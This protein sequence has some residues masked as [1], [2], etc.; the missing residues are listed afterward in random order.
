MAGHQE[1]A[2]A[3]EGNTQRLAA[4]EDRA[5][6][7]TVSEGPELDQAVLSTCCY[8]GR[9]RWMLHN[10]AHTL[11]V[12]CTSRRRRWVPVWLTQQCTA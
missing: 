9:R 8:H 1:V 6:A 10:A 12:P 4:A 11:V 2:I 3:R 7:D 5:L